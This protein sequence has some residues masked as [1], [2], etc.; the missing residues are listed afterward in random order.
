MGAV[1]VNNVVGLVPSTVKSVLPEDGAPTLK[2][3]VGYQAWG[4]GVAGL[5]APAWVTVN[6]LG[7]ASPCA[8][9]VNMIR[10]ACLANLLLGARLINKGNDASAAQTGFL[11]FGAWSLLMRNAINAGTFASQNFKLL[12]AWNLAMAVVS[13]RRQGGI[14]KSVTTLDTDGLNQILPK[15]K[16]IFSVRSIVGLQMLAWGAYILFAPG[17]FFARFGVGTAGRSGALVVSAMT[18]FFAKG[19]AVNNL[20]L[21]GKVLA[22]SDADAA[23]DGVVFFGGWCLLLSLAKSTGA[24][25]GAALAPCLYWNAAMAL[26]AA[27]KAM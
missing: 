12:A 7:A 5:V 6:V 1:S 14:W 19:L 9:S 22:G 21:G 3:A 26:L 25:S 8:S 17:N 4:W 10:G 23:K 2:N 15:D 20:I 13:A 16:E 18:A 27:K 24:V 11:W